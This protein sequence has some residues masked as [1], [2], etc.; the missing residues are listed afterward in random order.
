MAERSFNKPSGAKGFDNA[1]LLHPVQRQW[2]AL[3]PEQAHAPGL[4]PGQYALDDDWIE[5]REKQQFIDRRVMQALAL[6]NVSAARDHALIEQV[7]PEAFGWDEG[8]RA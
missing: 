3:K 8:L 7:L 1:S 6:G 4:L 5:Q 2:V